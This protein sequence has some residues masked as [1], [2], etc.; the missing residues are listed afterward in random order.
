VSL[1]AVSVV[2]ACNSSSSV[3]A[4]AST[5][6]LATATTSP[7]TTTPPTPPTTTAAAELRPGERILT[8]GVVRALAIDAAAVYAETS[9]DTTTPVGPNSIVRIDRKSGKTTE[10]GPILGYP[11]Q[12]V[13]TGRWLWTDDWPI[14][15]QGGHHAELVQLDA[16]TL[17]VRQRISLPDQSASLAA[18]PGGLW[19]GAPSRLLR[20]D[21]DT[22][23]IA[24]PIALQP[25][26]G[27]SV[28]TGPDGRLLYVAQGNVGLN[29]AKPNQ[30]YQTVVLSE[31]DAGN[32]RLLATRSDLP[33]VIGA[34]LAPIGA[35][36]GVWVS[37]PTGMLGQ[38]QLLRA[39]DLVTIA[40]FTR[41]VEAAGT[42]SADGTVS[43]DRLW[44][45]DQV[46]FVSCADRA[47][48]RLLATRSFT[49]TAVVSDGTT[50]YAATET[51]LALLK[52]DPAC[53]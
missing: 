36:N 48:G 4:A 13:S 30:P 47:T 29:P 15:P 27:T 40:T 49:A 26:D 43:G 23:R 7:T 24:A 10:S 46:G 3:G 11:G 1:L 39:S 45:T 17:A 53:N 2:T 38:V 8:L 34:A 20:L 22:G 5:A 52:P 25:G 51:G 37:F 31:R 12:L 19:V 14:G 33:S 41:F 16:V 6:P 9:P 44:V 50:L 18:V 35:P 32:G 42:N 21:P 28:A